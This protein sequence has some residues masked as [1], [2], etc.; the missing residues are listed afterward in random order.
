VNRHFCVYTYR[1][2][3]KLRIHFLNSKIDVFRISSCGESYVDNIL[4]LLLLLLLLLF[5]QYLLIAELQHSGLGCRHKH[6]SE[7]IFYER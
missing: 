2:T 7:C 5:L 1:K 4:S 6:I 3:S